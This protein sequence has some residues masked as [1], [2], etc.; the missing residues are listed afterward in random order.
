L[1]AAAAAALV[2][3]ANAVQRFA[4]CNPVSIILSDRKKYSELAGSLLHGAYGLYTEF[5]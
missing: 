5:L 1:T 3:N 4:K 2:V